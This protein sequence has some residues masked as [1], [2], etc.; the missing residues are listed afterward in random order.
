M[1]ME[2]IYLRAVIL[3]PRF[4]LFISSF[5]IFRLQ[6]AARKALQEAFAGK[7]DPFAL[8]EERRKKR[9]GGDG[10]GNGG[11]GGGGGGGGFN[12]NFGEFSDGFKKWWGNTLRAVAAVVFFF[13]FICLFYLWRPLLDLITKVVR[14]A[15]R[16][17]GNPRAQLAAGPAAQADLSK[18]DGLGNVE[19]S[20]ISKY[21]G[22]DDGESEEE[23][24]DEE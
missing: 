10:G 13:G 19:E 24:D 4:F 18:K 2:P 5:N 14:F 21:G 1:E 22:D 12:F 3:F 15:L 8:D 6:D 9:G 23:T 7:K 20:I 16:L 17:D 11:G